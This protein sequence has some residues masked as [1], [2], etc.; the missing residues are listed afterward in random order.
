MRTCRKLGRRVAG[1]IYDKFSSVVQ[2]AP[3]LHFVSYYQEAKGGVVQFSNAN[4]RYSPFHF[5]PDRLPPEGQPARL[6]WEWTP[7][8]VP[9]EEL[10]PYYD[11]VL[12][13]GPGFHP[14]DRFYH[15]KWHGG[16]WAVWERS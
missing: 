13:R 7:E 16:V 15:L 12:T 6:R 10:Y 2:W 11:Y 1:L 5:R 3:F 14:S 8:Q 9:V 4:V